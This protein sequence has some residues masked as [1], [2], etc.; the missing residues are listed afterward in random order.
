MSCF[1]VFTVPCRTI[2][3]FGSYNFAISYRQFPRSPKKEWRM[4]FLWSM[5]EMADINS[6]HVSLPRIQSYAPNKAIEEAKTCSLCMFPRSS[7]EYLVVSAI[8]ITKQQMIQKGRQGR[9]CEKNM[10]LSRRNKVT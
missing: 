6:I 7:K 2:V 5:L 1:Y 4:L 3:T 10:K 9:L 8:G